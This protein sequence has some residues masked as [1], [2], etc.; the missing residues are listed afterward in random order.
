[1]E[2]LYSV[3]F[4][5]TDTTRGVLDFLAA[6][7]QK[8]AED[9][10][11]TSYQ[12]KDL[13]KDFT[14]EDTVL[15]GVPSYAGR[16]SETFAQRFKENI[17]G[18]NTPAVIVITFGNRA[19]EDTLIELKDLAQANGFNVIAAAAVVTQHSIVPQFGA[20]RPDGQDKAELKNFAVQVKNKL[21][22]G[23]FDID[24]DVKVSGNRPYKDGMT[25]VMAPIVDKDKC[26]GCGTC[27]IACP[28]GA[29]D[30][31]SFECEKAKCIS[32]LRCIKVCPMNCRYVPEEILAKLKAHLAP[33]CASR[34]DNEFF[35]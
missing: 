9:V 3:F 17:K 13:Q 28:T 26:I 5:P 19:Y 35:I 27:V 6:G 32:C 15:I 10:D 18:N 24:A 21:E 12:N 29:I 2:K 30:K 31:S 16:V 4:S 1:M 22:K 23:E 34:K 20:G 33:L 11:L 14:A 8:A 7:M 25:G